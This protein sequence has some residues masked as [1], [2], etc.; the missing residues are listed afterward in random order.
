M[1]PGRKT[2][3]P[4]LKNLVDP[5]ITISNCT[6]HLP[7]VPSPVTFMADLAI[8]A[9]HTASMLDQFA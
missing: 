4:N 8:V 6:E 1:Q 3:I 9:R 7:P 5:S 2:P